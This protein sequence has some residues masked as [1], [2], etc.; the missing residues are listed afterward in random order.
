MPIGPFVGVEHKVHR[1]ALLIHSPG[2]ANG[3]PAFEPARLL[4]Q[5]FAAGRAR[6][7]GPRSTPWRMITAS[8]QR[9][10]GA[11]SLAAYLRMI[12]AISEF[13][14]TQSSRVALGS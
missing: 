2:G 13:L 7:F 4:R 9:L 5:F 3:T 1:A 6:D 12:S 10:S 14:M 11:I 8:S